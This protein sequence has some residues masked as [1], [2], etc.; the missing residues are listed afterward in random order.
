M[1]S[2]TRPMAFWLEVYLKMTSRNTPRIADM[3]VMESQ[4][5]IDA[6]GARKNPPIA[7]VTT[8]ILVIIGTRKSI[9]QY[10]LTREADL[11]QRRPLQEKLQAE[12]LPFQ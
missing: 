10:I 5:G 7:F 8:F 4:P 9:I 3:T 12:K 1:S 2:L 6:T 11:L